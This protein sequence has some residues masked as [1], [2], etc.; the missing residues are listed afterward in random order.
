ME[1]SAPLI[2]IIITDWILISC[3]ELASAAKSVQSRGCA[4]STPIPC[5]ALCTLRYKLDCETN[6]FDRGCF[7]LCLAVTVSHG[8]SIE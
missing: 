1:L 4:S 8:V 7:A 3:R 2:F 6:T 5:I